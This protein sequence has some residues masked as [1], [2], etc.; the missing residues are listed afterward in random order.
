MRSEQLELELGDERVRIPW[1]GQSPRGLTKAAKRFILV[2]SPTG[3]LYE[4]DR[5]Q[6]KIFLKGNHHGS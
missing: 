3:G 2:E 1:G 6:M 4:D 5:V